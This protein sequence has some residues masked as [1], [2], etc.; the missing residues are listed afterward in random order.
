MIIDFI[1]SLFYYRKMVKYFRDMEMLACDT[2]G[3]PI[4]YAWWHCR[5]GKLKEKDTSDDEIKYSD[6]WKP[7]YKQEPISKENLK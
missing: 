4:K 5:V 6:E 3:N 2:W 1:K 7:I